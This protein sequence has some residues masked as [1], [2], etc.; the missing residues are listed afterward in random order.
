[1]IELAIE[2]KTE[3]EEFKHLSENESFGMMAIAPPMCGL[4][5]GALLGGI[6]G[7]LCKL[8]PTLDITASQGALYGVLF[9]MVGIAFLA[10]V[11]FAVMIPGD[12]TQPLTSRMA[13]RALMLVSPLF[14]FPIVWYCVKWMVKRRPANAA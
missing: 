7:A 14:V 4:F 5:H 3:T 12:K 8:D 2:E 10:A 1:M 9:G 6:G 13:R 11:I